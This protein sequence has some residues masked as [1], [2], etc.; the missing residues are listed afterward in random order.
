MTRC[1]S[2]KLQ[3]KPLLSQNSNCLHSDWYFLAVIWI[4]EW[5]IV[6]G[7]D[8]DFAT[9]AYRQQVEALARRQ[10][11]Q[12]SFWCFPW[13][14]CIFNDYCPYILAL[15]CSVKLLCSQ[16]K[17]KNLKLKKQKMQMMKEM[18]PLGKTTKRAQPNVLGIKVG[19]R[20]P[21]QIFFF[22]KK[23]TTSIIKVSLLLKMGGKALAWFLRV[24]SVL[25]GP[26]EW[27]R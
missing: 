18:I 10:V 3:L 20:Q 21:Q 8:A 7:W 1:C 17:N 6:L 13:F 12:F 22:W 26:T 4:C 2:N 15:F 24:C 23:E 11:R 27:F 19:V 9:E 5:S 25:G 14:E 16:W